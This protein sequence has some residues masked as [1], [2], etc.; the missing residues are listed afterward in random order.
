MSLVHGY[1]YWFIKCLSVNGIFSIFT[2]FTFC[3]YFV[4]FM[5]SVRNWY[6]KLRHLITMCF[7]LNL[8]SSFPSKVIQ[9]NFSSNDTGYLFDKSQ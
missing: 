8:L 2:L 3:V 4:V 1:I 7:V 6:L 5:L 9:I